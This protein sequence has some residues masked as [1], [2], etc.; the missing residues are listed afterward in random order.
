MSNGGNSAWQSVEKRP[1]KV[2]AKTLCKVAGCPGSC[3][4]RVIENGYAGKRPR[5]TC[6]ECNATF[7]KPK[8]A[9]IAKG[10]GDGRQAAAPAAADKQGQ[11]AATR[12]VQLK[13]QKLAEMRKELEATKAQLK[14]AAKDSV[15]EASSDEPPEVAAAK[16][17]IQ[18]ARE[19]IKHLKGISSEAAAILGAEDIVARITA[20][21]LRIT[22]ADEVIRLSKPMDKQIVT[23]GNFLKK[24]NEKLEAAALLL[25]EKQQE[26]ADAQAEVDEANKLHVAAMATAARAQQELNELK[27]KDA[28]IGAPGPDPAVPPAL[29]HEQAHCA[30]ALLGQFAAM[31]THPASA[32]H[33]QQA[34]EASG[35]TIDVN[36]LQ[37]AAATQVP[38]PAPT[39]TPPTAA[40]SASSEDAPG[41]PADIVDTEM[42]ID[43]RLHSEWDLI[44]QSGSGL[45]GDEQQV[46]HF[47]SGWVANRR[48]AIEKECKIIKTIKKK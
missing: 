43:D 39:G 15:S 40:G 33:L 17:V 10:K 27:A 48:A 19:E 37:A 22:A 26:L 47:K 36:V 4:D 28:A 12:L 18:K 16:G 41:D 3:P 35:V 46:S 8:V 6:K 29:S 45:L 2:V 44:E 30:I 9:G 34:A 25:A 21:D 24:S 42:S 1:K 31:L 11:A 23:A 14:Q 38:A 5:A 20:A 32:G 13:D 7:P